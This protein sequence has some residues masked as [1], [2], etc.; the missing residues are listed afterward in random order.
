MRC[1]N[2]NMGKP[3]EQYGGKGITVCERW[4]KFENFLEDMGERPDGKT[5]DRINGKL[6]YFKENCRWATRREQH[7]NRSSNRNITINGVTHNYSEWGRIAGL[8]K[9]VIRWRVNH[10]FPP[11]ALLSK[12]Y[13]WKREA[14]K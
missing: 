12:R 1:Y 7:G 8:E 2:K 5:L 9:S 6:G 11:E 3:Y 10:G 14:A 13:E 4:H